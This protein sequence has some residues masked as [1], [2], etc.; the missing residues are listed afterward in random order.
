MVLNRPGAESRRQRLL[1]GILTRAGFVRGTNPRGWKADV[2]YV[3]S[4]ENRS[5][6]SSLGSKLRR[7]CNG[8]RFRYAFP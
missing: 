8:T 2:M 5:H 3:R 1:R 7:F 6:G 4:R